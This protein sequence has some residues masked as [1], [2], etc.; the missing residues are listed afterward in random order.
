MYTRVTTLNGVKDVDGFVA[1]MQETSLAVLRAQR[2]YKGLSVSADRSS[3]V[4]GTMTLWE[5]EADR[6]ASDSA[7]A[8]VRDDVRSQFASDM[9]IDTFEE[10][11]VEFS[12][13]PEVGSSLMVTRVSMDPAKADE[14]LEHFKREVLPQ[15]KATPGF[16]SLRIMGDPETGHGIVGSVWDDE[17]SM[18]A[19]AEA[20]MAR[21]PEAT[22]RGIDFGETSFREILLFDSV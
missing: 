13:A 16:R 11:I 4:I 5:T 3:G 21:R 14:N 9:T 6:D 19:A 8:K 17:Q 20:A 10:R 12:R 15:I 7:V 1:A 18:Q 22:A 2:G